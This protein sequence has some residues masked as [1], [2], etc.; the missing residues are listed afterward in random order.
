MENGKTVYDWAKI[1]RLYDDLLARHIKPFVELGFTPEALAT[2]QNSIFY[3]HGNTSHPKSEG[4]HDLSRIIRHIEDR[5]G[6]DE[7][8]SWYFEVY[9]IAEPFRL[10]GSRRSKGLL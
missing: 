2:S 5:Y 4:W 7:V 8:R 10:L 3:W 6:R 9:G 1:N